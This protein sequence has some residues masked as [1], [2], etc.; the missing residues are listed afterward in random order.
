M[1]D[2]FRGPLTREDERASS[3]RDQRKQLCA[4]VVP[5]IV[6][7]EQ[8]PLL[9]ANLRQPS[10]VVYSAREPL[11]E[12]DDVDAGVAQGQGYLR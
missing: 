11:N 8:Q 4:V 1:R 6:A 9:V 12:R 10:L 2:L 7:G 3:R 5:T